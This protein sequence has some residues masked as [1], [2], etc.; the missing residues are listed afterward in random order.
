[1]IDL[2][3]LMRKENWISSK[4][5]AIYITKSGQHDEACRLGIRKSGEETWLK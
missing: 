1:M 5:S 4:Y 2:T 3:F